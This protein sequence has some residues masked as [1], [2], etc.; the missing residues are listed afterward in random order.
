[1]AN[2]EGSQD[3]CLG[4]RVVGGTDSDNRANLRK[5]WHCTGKLQPSFVKLYYSNLPN[6]VF[7]LEFLRIG[8]VL[9]RKSLGKVSKGLGVV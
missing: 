7:L 8:P 4:G 2:P 3:T 6:S 9:I 1:M 5:N